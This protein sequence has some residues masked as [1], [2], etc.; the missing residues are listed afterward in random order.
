MYRGE[1]LIQHDNRIVTVFP[2][3][4]IYIYIYNYIYI[5]IYIYNTP[6]H[7]DKS[8]GGNGGGERNADEPDEHTCDLVA[9]GS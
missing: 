7:A 4:L 8:E 5:Y 3:T 6:R 1:A 9:D 2:D